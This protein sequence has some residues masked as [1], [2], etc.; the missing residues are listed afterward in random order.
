MDVLITGVKNDKDLMNRIMNVINSLRVKPAVKPA[1]IPATLPAVI[2][3][4]LPAVIPATLP[5]K[6]KCVFGFGDK[7]N[8]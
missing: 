1:V 4:T 7:S 5:L 3:A 8:I 2:P 6:R